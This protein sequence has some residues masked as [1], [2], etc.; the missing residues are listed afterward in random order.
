MKIFGTDSNHLVLLTTLAFACWLWPA[1]LEAAPTITYVQGNYTVPQTPQA[2]VSIGYAAGQVAGDLNVVVVGW[3][4]STAVVSAVTDSIGNTYTLAVG[5]TVQSGYASQSIYYAANIAPAAAGTNTVTVTFASAATSPDIRILEYSGADPVNPVDVTAANS[6]NSAT[7]DSSS[8]TITNATDL[9]FGANLVQVETMGPGGSFT[10]RLLTSPDGDIAEDQMVAATGSYSANAT[11]NTAGPWIMQMVAFRTPPIS[12]VQGNFATPQTPQTTMNVAYT[13]AQVAGDLNVVVVGWNDS[14]AVVSA[15]TDSSGNTYALAVGPTVQSGYASQS[16]Y[17]APNI[18]SAAAGANTVTVTFASAAICPDIRI[19]E[20]SG[21]DP[22]NPVDVTAANS[23]NS[24]ISYSGS[25]TTTNANDLIFGANLVLTATMGPGGGFAQRLLTMPDA[26]IAEDQMVAATGSYSASAPLNAPAPWIM[27]MVAFQT[28]SGGGAS[29]VTG[30]GVTAPPTVTSVSANS[31]PAAGGTAVTIAGTNF[32]AGAIVAFGGVGATNVVVVS[33]T[34]ITVTT[35]AGNAGAATVTVTNPGAQSVS[36]VNGFTYAAATTPAIGYVQD[37]SAASQTPQ[38]TVS[39]AYAAAQVSGDLNVVVVGWNDS[40][41]VVSGVTDSSGNTYTLAVGPTVQSG[42]ATQSIYYAPN[43][44]QAAA[45][46]NTVTVTFASAATFPDIRILEYSGADPNNPVDVTAAN[47]GNSATTD[48]GPATTTNATDLIFGANLGQAATI[49]PGAGFTQRLLPAPDGNVLEDQMVS[50]AGSYDAGAPLSASA[51]WI[52]QMVAFRTP[53]G[54][55]VPT[56]PGN[57]TATAAGANQINLSWTA[58]TSANGIANYVVQRCLG[59]G[60]TNFAQIAASAGTTYTDMGLSPSTSYNYQVQA[61]DTVGNASA[62]SSAATAATQAPPPPTAPGNLTAT[63]ASASQINLSWTA[64][65]SGY[66]I[67]YYVV[68][69][70]QGA[71]CTNFAQIA[72]SAGTIYSDAG[73]LSSTSY[74]YWVQAVDTAGNTSSL[75]NTATVATQAPPPPTAPGNLTATATGA[76]QINLSWTAST[77]GIGIADYVVQRCQGAGCT[78][79]AQIAA[80]A[81][82][83]YSDSGLLASTSYSYRAQAVDTGG[84]TSTF[85]NTSTAATQA[86]P[87]PTAPGNLTATAVSATQINLSWTASTSGIGIADYVVQRCQGAGCTNFVQTAILA[88]TGYS[89]TGLLASTSYSYQV[90]AVDTTGNAGTFSNPAAA[91]TQAPPP[92]TAPGNLTATVVGASQI[93]L[94]W[95]SSTSGI[96]IA[97]YVIQRCQGAG[98][99][100]FAQIATLTGTSY[101]DTGLSSNTSYSYQVQ[102]IDTAGNAGAFSSPA[103]AAT[104]ALQPPTAPGNLTATAAS[105]TQINLSWTAS[106][107]NVGLANYVVQ[108]CQGTDCTSFEQ[109][110]TVTGTSFT[111]T[112]LALSTSYGYEVAAIDTAGNLSPYSG[113]ASVTTGSLLPLQASPNNRYLVRQDGTPFLIMGDSPQSLVGNLSAGDMATYMA[114]REQLGFNSLW[115]NLLCTS[116]TGCNSN[117]TTYDGVAPFTSGSSPVDYDL[118]TPNSA[119]FTRVDSMVNLALTY[120][121]VVF[122][123]PIETGGWLDTLENNGST[124]AYNYGV[125]IGT[126]YKNFANIVWLHGNDFQSWSSSSTDNY[127]VEQVMA[128]IASVDSNHLQSIELNYDSSYSNQDSVLGSL[129]TLDSAYTYYE[130]Y[131]MVLQSYSSSPAIPTYLVESNYEYEN[132]TGAIPGNTGPYVLREQAYWTMLSGGTGQIYGNHYTWTFIPGWQSFLN[133]PGALEIQY[134]NQLFG[135]VS[136]WQ[137]VPDSTHQVVTA[138]YGTY[139]GSNQNLTTATYCTT[140]WITTGSLAL[141]YCPNPSRLT[142]DLAQFSGPVTA[143]WYDPSNGTYTAVPGAPFPN[144]GNQD[145][146]TP[147]NNHDGDPDWVLVLKGSL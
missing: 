24:G 53:L 69:R 20:Y 106:T 118:S 102:A 95:T 43:V 37:N 119:F 30:V 17:Y 90:Q 13:A 6:G 100:N 51:P 28:P 75:S 31:G 62:F 144:S 25:A 93:N 124:K 86:P 128:G 72:A 58:S 115:V 120:D 34:Q 36:L 91:A 79:F 134:I 122:L 78:N 74:S 121:L 137:L 146:T 42:Y 57:L 49:G 105:A 88:G 96:G 139:D 56:A 60:C 71:G 46:A 63:A 108:R 133:S 125:Y 113:V 48:S 2:T 44:A 107:S 85:S 114:N 16:I 40:S 140:S 7:S 65:A 77:S 66:G 126:R 141:T 35:P 26:D 83:S 84:N 80:P 59:A 64:S 68:E 129:L 143:Q 94:S 21:A 50:V 135:S 138:G 38:T 82:T 127:L 9:I 81:G 103:T 123:D 14:T 52:M 73:L 109:I 45:G 111:D 39:V 11:L 4:D 101:S 22:N 116:Y 112:G 10:Q 3:N 136:W 15:V 47:S 1:S 92:P 67:A 147:G 27:Q 12:Y 33:G 117:G 99:A 18:A 29:A 61:V 104:Q 5:P 142:V 23:G 97:D 41:T 55:T 110:A 89:D 98:C 130:T 8:A 19:L 76:S 145:F 32:A 70:C 132:N 87:P 131:D 54:N